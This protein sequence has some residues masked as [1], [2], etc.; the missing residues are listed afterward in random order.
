MMA[1]VLGARK[2]CDADPLVIE[3][4][5]LHLTSCPFPLHDRQADVFHDSRPCYQ[6]IL[7]A[8]SA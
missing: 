1:S 4:R 6:F 5:D 2:P 8:A 3:Q 7:F